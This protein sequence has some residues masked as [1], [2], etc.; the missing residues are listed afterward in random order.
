MGKI[1]YSDHVKK[2]DIS[3]IIA[4]IIFQS[5]K[6]T[7]N[8]LPLSEVVNTSSGGTPSRTNQ[9]YY[10]GEIPW[11]KSGEMNDDIITKSE[12]F[13]TESGL[14]NSSAKMFP[15]GTLLVAMYGATAGKTG[16]LDIDASTN[17]AVCAVIPKDKN[18]NR[19]F[20]FWFFR[21]NRF[22][23]IDISRGGAQP[24]ISQSV[25]GNT[26]FPIVEE[27]LQKNIAL[28]LSNLEQTK[29]ANYSLIPSYLCKPV[30]LTFDYL[31]CL[32]KLKNE[33]EKQSDIISQLKQAI[34]Q[35]AISGQ[36]TAEWRK[37][38]PIKKGNP[39]TEAAALLTQIKAEKQQL[40][41]DGKLKKEKPLPP[42]SPD[43]IPFSLPDGWVWCRLGDI[44]DAQDPNPSHRM[45]KYSQEGVPFISPMNVSKDGNIDF[46]KGKYV[47][48]ETLIIQKNIF[49]IQ[50]HSFAFSRIGTIGK[51]F[52]LPLPQN[53]CLSHSLSVITPV[54][55]E[56]NEFFMKLLS[57]NTILSQASKGVTHNTVPDLGMKTIRAF[58]C[59]LPPLAEQKAI[60]EKVDYLMKI[61]DQLE[62]QI[63]HRKQ[64][65]EDLMQTVLREAFE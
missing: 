38:N 65:A 29:E 11:L 18:I 17:Q 41:A 30:K 23:Y 46:L 64:L 45:P 36:L 16:I 4:E 12:E 56:E 47:L 19:D 22:Y 6:K 27:E 60:V 33:N 43:E 1:S 42:I 40:I 48:E 3:V 54:L 51:T 52:K 24:N 13:I 14:K 62:A 15:K 37:Q 53:Y 39:D 58:L 8:F 9:S 31:S 7:H 5:L 20:L 26:E 49:S 2:S 32:Q 34:L 28:F 10:N 21:A 59:P 35:E 63:Q 55:K 25:I 57:S 44:C 50:E 61:I